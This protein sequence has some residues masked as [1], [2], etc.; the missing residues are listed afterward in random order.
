MDKVPCEVHVLDLW[1]KEHQIERIDFI[2]IDVEGNEKYVLEGA[3]HVLAEYKPMV[4]CELLRKH[5]RRFGYHPNDVIGYMKN[6]GYDCV[7]I[8]NGSVIR[9]DAVDDTTKETNFF[10]LHRKRHVK[11]LES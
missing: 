4:Y 2:K 5:A 3:G 6:M 1:C 10:F 9:I 11:I 7:V 8:N